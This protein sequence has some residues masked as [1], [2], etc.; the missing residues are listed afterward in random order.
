LQAQGACRILGLSGHSRGIFPALAADRS[1]GLFHLRYNAANRGA[2]QEVFPF[3]GEN[4]P[5]I[6]VFSATRRMSLVK[7]RRIPDG[8]R[9]PEAADCYR[10]V[11]SHPS[12]DVVISAPSK[13]DQMKHNLSRLSARGPMSEEELAWMREV[14]D[15]VY[16]RGR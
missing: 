5:G 6:V 14:G 7:S 16:G 13:L 11:L 3:L 1:Y 9:R 15:R 4:P 2:E 8:L 10:F 12:V